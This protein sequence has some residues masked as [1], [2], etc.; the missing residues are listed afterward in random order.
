MRIY[1]N[2][3]LI[4]Y[5]IKIEALQ[6]QFAKELDNLNRLYSPVSAKLKLKRKNRLYVFGL[7][8]CLLAFLIVVTIANGI[9]Y[10]GLL[11]TC[12]LLNFAL[13]GLLYYLF[14]K[15]DK[16][17]KETT[18]DWDFQHN[19][20]L[21]QRQELN[22]LLEKAKE[23]IFK[24]IVETKYH[25]ELEE[26]RKENQ[27]RKIEDFFKSHINKI[28]EEVYSD[29]GKNASNE[30]VLIYYEKWGRKL[31][32]DQYYD[33]EQFLEARRRKANIMAHKEKTENE[34]VQK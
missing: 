7:T 24:V 1:G 20:L 18:K 9:D 22:E 15:V 4:K 3:E 26:L 32:V 21:E 19:N 16:D 12:Y 8:I 14:Y 31:T 23:E 25:N 10:Q 27:I 5:K 2:E 6:E 13:M 30:D 29:I 34:K 17:L 33:E 11:I 28:R